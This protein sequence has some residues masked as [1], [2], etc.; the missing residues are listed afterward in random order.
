LALESRLAFRERS[1][2][3][4]TLFDP[5]DQARDLFTGFEGKQLVR[6]I[7][8]LQRNISNNPGMWRINDGQAQIAKKPRKRKSSIW[9][10]RR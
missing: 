8:S 3:A 6:D 4:I 5:E 7:E 1:E 2:A 10:N 9:L